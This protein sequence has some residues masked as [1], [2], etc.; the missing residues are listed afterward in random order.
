MIV[1]YGWV[2]LGLTTA[3]TSSLA[4]YRYITMTCDPPSVFCGTGT[5]VLA[6]LAFLTA[7]LCMSAAEATWKRSEDTKNQGMAVQQMEEDADAKR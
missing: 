7:M 2:A 4:A 3:V 6:V 5:V 1:V